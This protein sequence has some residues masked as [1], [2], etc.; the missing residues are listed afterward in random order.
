MCSQKVHFSRAIYHVSKDL[1]LRGH[2]RVCVRLHAS[3]EGL[4]LLKYVP[5][6]KK[7]RLLET[8]L[9]EESFNLFG[10]IAKENKIRKKCP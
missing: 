10:V 4:Q 2:V 6:V 3:L 5:V 1:C 7:I 8:I 9:Y